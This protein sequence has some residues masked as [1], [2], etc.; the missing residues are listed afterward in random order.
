M[1]IFTAVDLE[2]GI[3]ERIGCF[4]D[5]LK[6][7]HEPVKWVETQNIHITLYFFGEVDTDS[8]VLLEEIIQ[9][10]VDG[11]AGFRIAV[12]GVSAFPSLERP[13]VIWVGVENPDGELIRIYRSIHKS[14]QERGELKRMRENK[15]YT[16]HITVGRV[17]ARWSTRSVQKL[18]ECQDVSFGSFEI[19]SVA[20][21]HS[22]L[23]PKGPI[24]EK[25][26]I[27]SL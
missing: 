26:R 7:A 4:V 17:K 12:R 24:Y 1:R 23:T 14:I 6:Q 22:K 21:Y 13:R 3:K 25:L 16:P 20:L 9:E 2:Q 27:F 10:S 15:E 11:V 5:E 19:G 8:V 18:R